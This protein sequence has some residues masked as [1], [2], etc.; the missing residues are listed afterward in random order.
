LTIVSSDTNAPAA[1]AIATVAHERRG[2]ASI[3][4]ATTFVAE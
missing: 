1:A 4:V 2:T 3:A